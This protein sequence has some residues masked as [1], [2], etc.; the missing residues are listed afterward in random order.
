M[1]P[2]ELMKALSEALAQSQSKLTAGGEPYAGFGD[3]MQVLAGALKD[4]Q[5]ELAPPPPEE[6]PGSKSV[7]KRQAK[8]RHPR[9]CG[10]GMTQSQLLDTS[11]WPPD[12]RTPWAVI[13]A[14]LQLAEVNSQ[15]LVYDLGCGDGRVLIAAAQ[16]QGARGVGIDI[17]RAMVTEAQEA[18]RE[19]G[20]EDLVQIRQGEARTT[21]FHRASVL[22]LFLGRKY[23]MQ[24][25]RSLR[26]HLK[27]GARVVSH[28]FDMGN[29][30]PT[31]TVM[32]KDESGHQHPLF[33]WKIESN[34]AEDAG[35]KAEDWEDW[36]DMLCRPQD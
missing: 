32:A 35:A 19:A 15:D 30:K 33:F 11:A 25:R 36:G 1:E 21:D 24:L 16:K 22:F 7:V 3:H 9:E 2:V 17:H 5:A 27:P 26:L 8:A 31:K 13:D 29:W 12:I 4:L 14:M 18:V 28:G 34:T 20:V 6:K 10:G 23:N